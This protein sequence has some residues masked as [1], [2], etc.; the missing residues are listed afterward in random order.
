LYLITLNK[1]FV[2]CFLC[3]MDDPFIHVCI[4]EGCYWGFL[5]S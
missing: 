5:F 3:S 2:L 4:R 1:H